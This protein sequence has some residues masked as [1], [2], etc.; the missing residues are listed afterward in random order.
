MIT[1]ITKRE[2]GGEGEIGR[3]EKNET[4]RER[5]GERERKEAKE[6]RCKRGEKYKNGKEEEKEKMRKNWDEKG[7]IKRGGRSGE[8]ETNK[9]G[10]MKE[11]GDGRVFK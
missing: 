5:G 8:R 11:R 2:R 9:D 3:G 10:G 1:K 7:G 6:G 4:R